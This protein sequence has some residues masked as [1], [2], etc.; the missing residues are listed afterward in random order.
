VVFLLSPLAI[1]TGLAM[2]PSLAARFPWY[3]RLFRGRQAAR[4]IHFLCLC[5]FL[6]FFV[7]HLAM[8]IAHG[9]ISEMGL[10]VLGD[11]QHV[12]GALGLLVGLAGLAGVVVIHVVATWYSLRYPRL[13]QRRTQAITEPLRRAL[14]EHGRSVQQYDP[15]EISPYFR[16][17]GRPPAD[18]AYAAMVRDDFASFVLDVDGL[19]ER[20][21]QLTLA[22][23]RR[24]PKRQQITKHC[25]IQGWS[26]VASWGGVSLDDIVQRCRPLAEARYVVFYALDDKSTSE[27]DPAGPGSFY[28][29]IDIALASHSQTILAYEMNDR[30]LPV[31]H[32]APLRLRVETQLGFTM[33]KYVHRIE[34]VRDYGRIGAGQGGWREDHQYYSQEAGI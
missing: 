5:A 20:P 30:P 3:I 10:I 8:V 29:T 27:P 23:L 17:N 7:V 15:A 2:S 11:V 26:A 12:H 34:F 31:P 9:E 33:V 28:G 24:W 32:G 21:L 14:F 25:C 4:S 16:V 18:A 19:V 22:E 13:V 1:A 6:A